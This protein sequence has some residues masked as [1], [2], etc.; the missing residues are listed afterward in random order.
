MIQGKY[1]TIAE[2]ISDLQARGY[3]LDFTIVGNKLFCSQEKCYIQQDEFA[4]LEKYDFRR[5]GRNKKEKVVYGIES[6]F[7]M[8][9]GILLSPGPLRSNSYSTSSPGSVRF[10]YRRFPNVGIASLC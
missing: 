5:G 2:A 1:N 7:R 3:V 10:E 4:V 8:L 9:K 6:P